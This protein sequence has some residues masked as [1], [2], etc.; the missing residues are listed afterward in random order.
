VTHLLSNA[1]HLVTDG[2]HLVCTSN[3]STC[4]CCGSGGGGAPT[5]CTICTTM[6]SKIK[7]TIANVAT[8]AN[9]S[10]NI[11]CCD[12]WNS[13]FLLTQIGGNF[14][15]NYFIAFPLCSGRYGAINVIINSGS[16]LAPP[17]N[18]TAQLILSNALLT[19][20]PAGVVPYASPADVL[21]L[22][23]WSFATSADC[24]A[25][26]DTTLSPGGGMGGGSGS[27]LCCDITGTFPS[28]TTVEIA[29]VP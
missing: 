16:A 6:P 13:A 21:Y 2:T 15:C 23:S 12:D 5:G 17:Y 22:S 7:V 9:T 10:N 11:A 27:E 28:S 19:A 4:H 14:P 29:P 18:I 8:D 25:F 20:T 3:A 24:N 1:A 26:A